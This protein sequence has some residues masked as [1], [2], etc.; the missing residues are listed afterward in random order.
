[1][2]CTHCGKEINADAVI[3]LNCGV[4]SG[5]SLPKKQP[6]QSAPPKKKTN[7]LSLAGFIIAVSSVGL[8]L[9]TAFINSL[10]N[11][12]INVI[13]ILV[14]SLPTALGLSIA[15]TVKAKK[16]KTGLGFGISGI[17]ISAAT[18]IILVLLFIF[19]VLAVSALVYLIFLILG[20]V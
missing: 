20:S 6:V 12:G 5:K 13:F 8:L 7:G 16:T 4:L 17:V 3:C 1:M 19:A 10:L 18:I 9:F 11:T 14:L 2:Y 15:G